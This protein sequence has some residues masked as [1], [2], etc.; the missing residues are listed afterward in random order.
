MY[1]R[2]GRLNNNIAVLTLCS[3]MYT[4]QYQLI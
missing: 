4:K 2:A 1:K 3:E